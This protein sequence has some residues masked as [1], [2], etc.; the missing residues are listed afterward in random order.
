[1]NPT[2]SLGLGFLT[3]GICGTNVGVSGYV[4]LSKGARKFPTTYQAVISL[5]VVDTNKRFTNVLVF[6]KHNT[7][8]T[9]I[10]KNKRQK[11]HP[12]AIKP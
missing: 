3:L 11:L 10:I 4:L 12:V 6:H 1:M 8:I 9:E 7:S 2:K 5:F